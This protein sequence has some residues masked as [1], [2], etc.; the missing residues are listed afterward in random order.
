MSLN[1]PMYIG[2]SGLN[3]FSAAINVT[4]D[5]IANANTTG[6][7]SSNVRFGDMVS[8]YYSTQG[9][10][11]DRM[12]A[13]SSVLGIATNFSEGSMISTNTWS[14]VAVNGDGYFSVKDPAGTTPYYTRDGDFHVDKSGNLVNG[15]GYQVLDTT[16]APIVVDTPATPQYTNY[17]IDTKG[18]IWGTPVAGGAAVAIGNP[19]QLSTFPNQDGLIRHGNNLYVA[20]GDAGTAVTGAPN[21]G[22][23]GSLQNNTLEGS[24]VDLGSEMV[25]LIVYHAD[26]N[27]NSK[28]IT[29]ANDMMTTVVNLIR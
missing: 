9:V 16:G 24:N 25:N 21:S 7:K 23:R 18:Q 8:S 26:Y 12:G 29:T 13:G 28:S 11:P 20:G 17:S 10:D 5:N 4:S 22:P 14:N 3:S 19:L 2:I 1:S 15:L 27:A 6:F